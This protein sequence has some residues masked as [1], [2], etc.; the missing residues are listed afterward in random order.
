MTSYDKNDPETIREMFNSIAKSYDKANGILSFQMHKRWNNALVREAIM[1]Y[2][3][4]KLLDLCCGT[5]EIAFSYLRQSTAHEPKVY[6]LDFSEEMLS[7]ARE[8]AEA[9]N[10]SHYDVVYFQADA[11]SIP[12]PNSYIDCTTMAYGIR[13]IK[14]PKIC[15]DDVYRVLKPGGTFGILELTQPSNP[16]MRLGHTLYL[17]TVLPLMGKIITS[18]KQAY[19]YLCRSI[20]TFIPPEKLEEMIK[21]AGFKDIKR[22]SLCGGVATILIGKKKI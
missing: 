7:Y 10:L 22:L 15:I 9:D 17:R 6:L 11:Q 21:N 20:N 14:N 16:L 4:E 18:N 12:L 19:D 3:P 1:P 13:N 2:R 8:K 5:G